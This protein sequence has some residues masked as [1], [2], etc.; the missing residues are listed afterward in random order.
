[1]VNWENMKLID[2]AIPQFSTTPSHYPKHSVAEYESRL[3]RTR[4]AMERSG[5]THLVVYGD[6]EHSANL[7]WLTGFDPRFEESLLILRLE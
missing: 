6:R 1:V 7:A 5:L 2:T 3:A 4:A